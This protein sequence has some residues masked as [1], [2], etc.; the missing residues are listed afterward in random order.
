MREEITFCRLC[1]GS[2]GMVATI[3]DDGRIAGLRAQKE[4]VLTQ[5]YAC[6]KGLKAAEF[7][8]SDRRLLR[9]HRR[10]ADGGFEPVGLEE[11]LDDVADRLAKIIARDGPHA[12]SCFIGTAGY[13]NASAYA[14][15]PQ[16]MAAIG[17]RST[18]SSLTI[19]QSA[20]LV[21]LGR[22]GGWAAGRQRTE[23]ADVWMFVGTNPLVSL[24]SSSG[25]PP[26]NGQRRL[27]AAKARG[28][29][30][31]VIDPRRTETASLADLH[32]QPLPGRD[33]AIMAALLRLILANGWEDR[34]FCER[35][36]GGLDRL[37][38]AVAPF[39]PEQV[40]AYSGVPAHDIA[41]AAALW[42]ETPRRGCAGT[43]TG[44]CMSAG[45]NLA[46]HMVELMN[47]VCGRYLRAGDPVAN[48]GPADGPTIK[49][50]QV[51]APNRSWDKGHRS[52]I[53][54]VGTFPAMFGVEMAAG[55]MADEMLTPG[56][57]R[58]RAMIVVGGNPATAVPDQRKMVKAFESLEL[59]V[60]I[61]PYLS[62]TARLAH[63]VFPPKMMYER[64][65]L[66]MIYGQS[67]RP[68]APFLQY[69]P[70]VAD[71]PAGSELIDD[72]YL[73]WALAKRL[74]IPLDFCGTRLDSE[75]PPSTEDLL[76]LILGNAQVPFEEIKRNRS[77][78]IYDLGVQHVEAASPDNAARFDVMPDDVAAELGAVATAMQAGGAIGT[79]FPYL[80][81]SRR[82]RDAMNSVSAEAP[83][84]H[85][86]LPYNP[87]WVH[88]A[89]LAELG[90]ADGDPVE[91]ASDTGSI[92]AVA[93]ADSS[94]RVGVVQMSHCFGGLPDEALPF[95]AAGACTNLLVST[96]RD[97]EEINAMPRQSGIPVRLRAIKP[98]GRS[99]SAA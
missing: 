66:P 52:R 47:V 73:F 26:Y 37:R 49:R 39:T 58:Q 89:D 79:A 17:S 48:P 86:R 97:C 99:L 3:D 13:M 40:A 15:A 51:I 23:D 76:A 2:C 36:V 10:R 81:A 22:L 90:L 88:P 20:K 61:D 33:A 87:L 85:Q 65:D 6:F 8:Y 28:M 95:E 46:D 9:P 72:W 12:I 68:P 31:I 69:T 38:D 32:L 16:W 7:H 4:H 25:L 27:K 30:L 55:I 60:A 45:S 84:V 1:P 19:D 78:K 57:D 53:R 24:S 35:Y 42:A 18:Y 62:A 83:S 71:P 93:K 56:Q 74:N 50:A 29:K 94:V 96:D 82:L 41:A 98:A 63:Y 77:G 5:G 21:T 92:R 64:A 34:D 67:R 75:T 11:A 43:G 44:A 80:L 70:A 14:M 59:L 91:I 54:G